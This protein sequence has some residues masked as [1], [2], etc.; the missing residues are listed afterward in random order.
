VNRAALLATVAFAGVLLAIVGWL[1]VGAVRAHE[2]GDLDIRGVQLL[3]WAIVGH[4]TL[5]VLIG[6]TAFL[7]N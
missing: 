2:R 7:T 4:L 1:Y 3:R 5:Y 6:V